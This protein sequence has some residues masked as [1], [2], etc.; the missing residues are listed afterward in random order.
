MIAAPPVSQRRESAAKQ[1]APTPARA[2]GPGAHGGPT[3]RQTGIGAVVS[4]GLPSNVRRGG[5]QQIAS[6]R[7]MQRTCGNHAVQRQLKLVAANGALNVQRDLSL[8]DVIPGAIL[9]PVRSLVGQAGFFVSG[10]T[11]KSDKAAAGAQTEADAAATEA[12][13]GSTS[14][15]V[16]E[17]LHAE[18]A[19][20]QSA[21]R[22]GTAEVAG[23][24]GKAGGAAQARQMHSAVPAAEFA[25]DPV[26]PAIQM[27]PGGVLPGGAPAATPSAGDTWNCDESA[28]VGR[29]SAVRKEV[30]QSLT[31]AVKA[32]VPEEVLQFAQ[33]GVAK[34][35]SVV[36]GIKQ[37]VDAAK[38]AVTKWIDDR[39]APVRNAVQQAEHFVSEKIDGAKKAI[40][41]AISDAT[42]W[43]SKKW[44]ALKTQV[45]TK[46]N[47]AIEWAKRGA[48]GLLQKAKDLAGRFWDLVPE[49]IKGP[50]AG[51][52]T[53]LAA[54]I[55]LASKAVDSTA[56]WVE[57]KSG[58]LKQKLVAAA[59]RA[60]QWLSVKYQKVRAL[61]V[62]AGEGFSKGIAWVRTRAADAGKFVYDAIDKLSGDRISKWRA[63]AAARLSELKG[64]ACAFAGAT[65]GP[66]VERFIPQPSGAGGKS[67]ATLAT[68]TDITVPIEGVPVKIA[69]GAKITIERTAGTYKAILSGEGSAGVAVKLSGGSGGAGG[70][71]GSS[72]TLSVDG[73]LPNRALALLSL[74][75]QAPAL[76]A[77]P[78]PIGAAPKAPPVANG[79]QGTSP[80][81]QTA[82]SAPGGGSVDASA[83]AGTKVSVALTYLFDADPARKSTCDGLG[84]LSAFLA[85][86]GAAALLPA[87]FS[88]LAA[89]G[90]QA[91]F[92]DKLASAKMTYA[93][94]GGVSAKGSV[95][96]AKGS[97]GVKMESGASLEAKTDG[98]SKSIVL[99]LFQGLSGE[100]AISFVPDGIGLAKVSASLGGRQELGITYNI[101]LDMANASFKQSLSGSATLGTFAGMLDSLPP[102]IRDPIRQRIPCLPNANEATVSFELS[103]NVANLRALAQALDSELNK[104]SGATAAGVWELVGGFLKDKNNS[105]IEFSAKLSLTEKVL[106][107][108]ASASGDGVSG[109]AELS[110]TRGQEIELCPPIR[111]FGG[112]IAAPAVGGAPPA[113]APRIAMPPPAAAKQVAPTSPPSR[114]AVEAFFHGST[115][116][117]A[118]AIPGHVKPIGGGDFGQG[119]YTHHHEDSNVAAERARWEGC[120]LC[121]KMSPKEQYAGVIRFGVKAADYE[122]LF[123]NR[124]SFGLTTTTQP[125]YSTKQK[126][127]L[128][129]VSGPG[130]GREACPVFDPAHMSWRHQRVDPPPDQGHDLIEGPMYKGVEG[131]PGAGIPPR[132][133][134]DPYAEGTQLPQQIVWNHDR[135]MAVLNAS[136]TT[137]KQYDALHDCKPVDP[138]ASVAALGGPLVEDARAREAA[139]AEMTGG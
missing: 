115:W 19:A 23:Q 116:R 106:G 109:S 34:L 86:Q 136:T 56:T 39:M 82:G 60:T 65:A 10:V 6:L 76:P 112:G 1:V 129:F 53:A 114:P 15:L 71:G 32:V 84:G 59:D 108:N 58:W 63:A 33:R 64:E 137:L 110:V 111:P 37:K 96:P 130:R 67:F 127:W 38:H 102:A 49:A 77:V 45:S 135:A 101:T 125:D 61:V 134:F 51:A 93:N 42:A 85:S 31:K 26:R 9:N 94:T 122:G 126:E 98:K 78:V 105:Y 28:I 88:H 87:P 62:R 95:G 24:S 35:Q 27:P 7:H 41:G 13:G 5:A 121:Q 79:P 18:S 92:Q 97:A 12:E 104:G 44:T 73:T 29:V 99:T 107:V 16:T 69:A 132:S 55:V 90:G 91:A 50:L 128:D 3:L 70:G 21:A 103:N 89:A 72:G 75:G 123:P 118:Q 83:E 80:A 120:R 48:S 66:C 22:V 131:L 36:G 81:P 57:K 74:S 4:L 46:V 113:S 25:T 11:A 20:S 8:D 117:I 14:K 138:P 47:E 119:F 43:A 30:V 68:K 100:G 124:K 40:S 54:P 2:V 52:A 133:A 17:T 139:Q